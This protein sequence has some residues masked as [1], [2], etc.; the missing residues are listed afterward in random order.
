MASHLS[1]A[2][3]PSQTMG[4]A[5]GVRSED[6]SVNKVELIGTIDGRPQAGQCERQ[7]SLVGLVVV[8]TEAV[9]DSESNE[10]KNRKSWHRVIIEDQDLAA[11][12]L[13]TIK[14][15]DLIH[16]E[17]QLRTNKVRDALFVEHILTEVVLLP[18]RG[19]LT[20]YGSGGARSVQGGRVL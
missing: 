10:R 15:G 17:G 3:Q 6:I 4:C 11:F 16:V 1:A 5:R 8:T 18:E 9:S 19:R 20:V 2:I 13:R 14:D 7:T 12:A